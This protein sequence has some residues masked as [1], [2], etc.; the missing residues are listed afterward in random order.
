MEMIMITAPSSG[1]G[2]TLITL[3]IIRA[4]KK[5]QCNV[6][7]FKTGPDFIDTRYIAEASGKRAGNLDMHLLGTNGVKKAIAMNKG[8]ISIAEGAMGYFDGMGSGFENSGYDISKLLDINAI[9]VY[10]P[11]G[12]MFSAIPKIKGMVDFSGSRIR[13]VI[14]NKVSRAM[15]ALLKEKIEEYIDVKVLGYVEEDKALEIESRHL[16]LIQSIETSDANKI[17]EKAAENI[18]KNINLEEIIRLCRRVELPEYIYPGRRDIRVAIAYDKAF[19]F[20]YGE[21]LNLFENTCR[22]EYFSPIEDRK[23][24]QCDLLYLGGGYPE[25]YKEELSANYEMRK[26]VKDK[27][28]GGGFIY[29][30]AGGL[31]YLAG[32]IEQSPMCGVFKGKSA[33]TDRLQRFG[34]VNIEL[35]EDCSLGRKGDLIKGQEFHKSIAEIN[36]KEIFNIKKPMGRGEWK[37]GYKY[38]N[39][40]AAYPHIN[41]LGNM[42]AFNHLLDTIEK[43]YS[44]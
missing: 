34:Y 14:L 39:A 2:K 21:N 33:M 4:L 8:D 29:A 27:A 23:L 1:M 5:R 40:L 11:K 13:G 22:V 24:P 37:C 17:I 30:E 41:F 44:E 31:M 16:G 12:E 9:L 36:E 6:S 10:T 35:G 32:S 19:S 15:Y 18:E 42:K 3:G 43:E 7:G 20:Y 25:I 28:E 26:A 38:K